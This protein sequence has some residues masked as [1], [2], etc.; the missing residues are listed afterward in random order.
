MNI[1]CR[2]QT[3]PTQCPQAGRFVVRKTGV[4]VHTEVSA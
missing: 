4:S 2:K 1:M 3:M